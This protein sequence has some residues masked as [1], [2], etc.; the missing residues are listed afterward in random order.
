MKRNLMFKRSVYEDPVL[1]RL[2]LNIPPETGREQIGV[3]KLD[4]LR[5]LGRVTEF[6][7][8]LH[9]LPAKI[10]FSMSSS[11]G[12]VTN[13]PETPMRSPHLSW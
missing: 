12:G 8:N 5:R 6:L 4:A 9:I 3:D 11:R 7:R 2:R 1:T 13:T 10:M